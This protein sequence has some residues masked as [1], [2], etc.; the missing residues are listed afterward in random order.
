MIYVTHDQVEAMTLGD[1]IVVLDK[2][3]IQQIDTP[4][5]L[6]E[7][8]ASM[9]VAGFIGSPA[10]NFLRGRVVEEGLLLDD[11]A[12]LLPF[13]LPAF[14]G[15][16]GRQIVLGIRPEDLQPSDRIDEAAI[17]AL[18]EVA[19]PVGNETFLNLR[20]GNQA[21]VA[22]SSSRTIPAAGSRLRIGF[23]TDCLHAFDPHD[24]RRIDPC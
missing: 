24:E 11:G 18:L 7:R 22:R 14:A 16:I 17:D 2:G 15:F 9:F 21:L 13:S 4:R 6:Y 20:F 12:T 19:E 3:V 5:N 23:R 8:P 10:M 1:R